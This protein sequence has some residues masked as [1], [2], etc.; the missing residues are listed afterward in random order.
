[1]NLVRKLIPKYNG[2]GL[3]S[4]KNYYIT[5]IKKVGLNFLINGKKNFIFHKFNLTNKNKIYKLFKYSNITHIYHFAAQAGV[6]HS[7]QYPEYY[8]KN[9]LIAFFDIL[10]FTKK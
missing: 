1:M 2:I 7:L 5:K 3:D 9:N 10:D 6:W 4:L 8:V